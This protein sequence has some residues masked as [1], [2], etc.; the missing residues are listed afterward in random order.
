MLKINPHTL[1]GKWKAVFLLHVFMENKFQITNV[2]I[3]K[4][5]NTKAVDKKGFSNTIDFLISCEWLKIHEK[6]NIIN[7][8]FLKVRKL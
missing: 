7:E 6:L 4:I 8:M 3:F 1:Q 2:I 5:A